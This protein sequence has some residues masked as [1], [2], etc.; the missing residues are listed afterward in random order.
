MKPLERP[1]TWNLTRFTET[2]APKPGVPQPAPDE[3]GVHQGQTDA[4]KSRPR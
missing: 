1:E 2:F 3:A 4:D